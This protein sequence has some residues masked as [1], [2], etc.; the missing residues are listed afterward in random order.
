VTYLVVVTPNA[1]EQLR[2]ANRFIRRQAP[3]AARARLKGARQKMKSLAHHPERA[4]LAPESVS[5]EEPIR[6][7]FYGSGNRVYVLHFRHGSMSAL[8]PRR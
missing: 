7:V 2:A 3:E 1:E 6:E 4:V 5:F 8:K